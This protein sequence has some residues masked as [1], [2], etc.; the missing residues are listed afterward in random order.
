M[1]IVVATCGC[2]SKRMG[3]LFAC[4]HFPFSFSFS[5]FFFPFEMNFCLGLKS[6]DCST[7]TSQVPVLQMCT[8]TPGSG[9]F[10]LAP[11]PHGKLIPLKPSLTHSLLRLV[12]EMTVLFLGAWQPFSLGAICQCRLR[13]SLP[14][15]AR[16]ATTKHA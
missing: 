1:L 7:S 8:T 9:H 11:G 15:F 5:S 4:S 10:S 6:C 3:G 14:G 2:R 16:A 12:A 13:E